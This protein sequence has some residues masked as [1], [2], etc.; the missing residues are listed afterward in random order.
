MESSMQSEPAI[1]SAYPQHEISVGERHFSYREA[2]SGPALVL[3]HGIGSG[4]GSWVHQLGALAESFRVIA[5]D[6]PGYGASAR[7][8][9]PSPV[10]ADYAA[11]LE[12]L[13][14]ALDVQRCLLVGH[15]LGALM[16]G[17]FAADRPQRVRGLVLGNPARGY[18]DATPE[19]RAEKLNNRLKQI[20]RLGPEGLARERG[21][22]L[23]SPQAPAE[24]VEL[25]RWNMARLR[26]DGHEQAARLLSNGTLKRDVARWAG[27]LMVIWG[28]ADTIT[29]PAACKSVADVHPS[30]RTFEI[31]GAGHASYV[32]KPEIFNRLLGEF[33]ASL[34]QE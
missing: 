20:E 1:L 3:L 4:S 34:K 26:L 18:G 25:V 22:A 7:I 19:E 32:E 5:W 24:A 11:A 17:S 12:A 8:V 10:A 21:P 27:P 13:L 16:A 23:L 15:S 14:G 33:A 30:A 6:A 29:P 9:P 31:E 28:S 2:G